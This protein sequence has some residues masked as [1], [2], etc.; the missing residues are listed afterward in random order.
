MFGE[1]KAFGND[2]VLWEYV[3][4]FTPTTIEGEII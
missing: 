3:N 4:Y 1:D 2:R